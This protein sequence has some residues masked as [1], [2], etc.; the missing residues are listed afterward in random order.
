MNIMEPKT[1]ILLA[2]ENLERI[3]SRLASSGDISNNDVQL[4]RNNLDH[5]HTVRKSLDFYD[6]HPVYMVIH[7]ELHRML[8]GNI[9]V[10]AF[11]INIK[12]KA[13]NHAPA[14]LNFDLYPKQITFS[15]FDIND[16]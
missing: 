14:V 8:K 11:Q 15:E 12:L 6:K 10:Y 4:I 13:G 3:V 2:T 1:A 7:Q 9:P 16:Y 5:L